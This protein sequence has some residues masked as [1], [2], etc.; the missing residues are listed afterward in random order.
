MLRQGLS[1]SG[2]PSLSSI[3]R[4]TLIKQFLKMPSKM[5][6]F[7]KAAVS[8]LL[9]VFKSKTGKT[10]SIIQSQQV[11]ITEKRNLIVGGSIFKSKVHIGTFPPYLRKERNIF[12][13]ESTE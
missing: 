7:A 3:N 12:I 10:F 9:I 11:I 2:T 4:E 13:S 1:V 8:R 6:Y 5:S